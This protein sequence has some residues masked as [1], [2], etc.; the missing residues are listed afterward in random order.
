MNWT[1][2]ALD[3]FGRTVATMDDSSHVRVLVRIHSIMR[4]ERPV[5]IIVSTKQETKYPNQ[6]RI[7]GYQGSLDNSTNDRGAAPIE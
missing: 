1:M 7:T 4:R 3:N 5:R 6:T 2:R